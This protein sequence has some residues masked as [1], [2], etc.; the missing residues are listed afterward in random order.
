MHDPLILRIFK[1][2]AVRHHAESAFFEAAKFKK[3][4]EADFVLH[5]LKY[6]I[7]NFTNLLLKCSMHIHNLEK[8]IK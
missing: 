4:E 1:I 5:H 8:R 7:L 2:S 3:V 6:G